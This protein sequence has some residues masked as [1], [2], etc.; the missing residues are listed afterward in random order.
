MGG[1]TIENVKARLTSIFLKVLRKIAK[2][3]AVKTDGLRAEI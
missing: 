1:R 3:K 2:K